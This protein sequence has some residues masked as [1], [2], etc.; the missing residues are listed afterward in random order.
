[1][2]TDNNNPQINKFIPETM[3]EFIQS[4]LFDPDFRKDHCLDCR[5]HKPQYICLKCKADIHEGYVDVVLRGNECRRVTL[6]E[7]PGK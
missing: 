4:L 2:N 5:H 3:D 7:E 6:T 1:M